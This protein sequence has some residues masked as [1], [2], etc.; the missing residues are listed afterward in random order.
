[1]ASRAA[2]IARTR[3]DGVLGVTA[4]TALAP[5]SWGTTYLVTTDSSRPVTR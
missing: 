3:G 4:L 1:M 2:S 5:A